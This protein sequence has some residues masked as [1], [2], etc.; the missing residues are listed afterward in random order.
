M[1]PLEH[2]PDRYSRLITSTTALIK[3]KR[4]SKTKLEARILCWKTQACRITQNIVLVRVTSLITSWF[5]VT[6]CWL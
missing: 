3:N 2:H 6:T 5:L 4:I 1:T